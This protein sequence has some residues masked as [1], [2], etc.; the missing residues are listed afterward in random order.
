[1]AS[2]VASEQGHF[3]TQAGAIGRGWGARTR[4]DAQ[5]D[6]NLM[7]SP[8]RA[9][10]ISQNHS[11]SDYESSVILVSVWCH[12]VTSKCHLVSFSVVLVSFSVIRMSISVLL[13]EF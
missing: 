9:G 11:Q 3:D 13:I 12:A 10:A 7:L 1:M 8:T 6:M 5:S 2:C 4:A